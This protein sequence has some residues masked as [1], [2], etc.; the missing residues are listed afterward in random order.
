VSTALT[1]A[2]AIDE[3]VRYDPDG[4]EPGFL[5]EVIDGFVVRKTVGASE[6]RLA[7]RLERFLSPVLTACGFG[8][9]YVELGYELPQGGP[10]R[11]PGVS[12]LSFGRWPKDRPFPKG[13]FL[14]V[15]PDLAV[16]VVSPHE[17]SR[18]TAAKIRDYFRGGVSVVWVI[19]PN[20][21]QV[22]IYTSPSAIRILTKADD[23][24]ADPLFPG[25]RL[26]LAELFPAADESTT[27]SAS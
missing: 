27:P 26:P 14:P 11:K 24:T 21:E 16:E 6:V 23:L 25:F 3:P 8:E 15:A 4:P 5:F 7:N 2:P 12:I 18:A 20:V 13:D 19:F 22:H 10:G 1:D 9:S 17:T